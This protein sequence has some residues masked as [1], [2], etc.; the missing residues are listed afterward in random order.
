LQIIMVIL[1]VVLPT[2]L[3]TSQTFTPKGLKD[4]IFSTYYE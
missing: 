3:A 4:K 1:Y 2:L